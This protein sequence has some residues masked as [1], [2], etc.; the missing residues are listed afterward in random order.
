MICTDT[1][2]NLYYS[3]YYGTWR[4]PAPVVQVVHDDAF[5]GTTIISN[6]NTNPFTTIISN[7]NT[8]T[9][10]NTYSILLVIIRSV[11]PSIFLFVYNTISIRAL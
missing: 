6:T 11:L 10:T 4:E 1:Y 7:T 9:N 8:N 5:D 3:V 2:Y